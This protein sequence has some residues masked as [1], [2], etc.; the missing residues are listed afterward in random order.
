MNPLNDTLFVNICTA[1]N[2]KMMIILEGCSG[3]SRI[4]S[5]NYLG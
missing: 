2:D 1:L 5:L 4:I 3:S